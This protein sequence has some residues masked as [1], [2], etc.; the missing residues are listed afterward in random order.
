MKIV[1]IHYKVSKKIQFYSEIKEEA[2]K[3]KRYVARGSFEGY[4]NKAFSMSHAQVSETPYCF[5]VVAQ[6]CINEKMFVNRVIIN[7]QIISAST[8]NVL[9][10]KNIDTEQEEIILLPNIIEYQEMCMSF[11]FRKP[12]GVKRYNNIEVQYQVPG[13]F[14]LK[15][16]HCNLSGI[17]SEIFQHEYDH[18]IGKNIYFES[19][20][21][22]VWWE[23]IGNTKP[24]VGSALEHFDPRGLEVSKENNS[25]FTGTTYA[26]K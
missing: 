2:E 18:T 26:R 25:E 20:K 4:Y 8:D 22:V 24:I 23:L 13:I 3:M 1:K 14:G 21:P 10:D 16:I 15:T 6:E 7:P 11:P 12:K 19:E 17:A 5:F 9:K